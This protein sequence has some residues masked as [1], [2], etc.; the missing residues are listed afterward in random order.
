[1]AIIIVLLIIIAIIFLIFFFNPITQYSLQKSAD[2]Q[3]F[4]KKYEGDYL[5]PNLVK[6]I[7]QYCNNSRLL[8]QII[9][10]HN[11]TIKEFEGI[12]MYLISNCPIEHKGHFI[13]I[14]TFFF[15]Q[16]LDYALSK[17]LLWTKEDSEWLIRYF[18]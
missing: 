7:Y 5:N 16:S 18:D 2:L 12:Y 17:K 14:S 3:T 15:A 1:M 11:A 10:K 4:I 6:E 9:L 13:P 8:N